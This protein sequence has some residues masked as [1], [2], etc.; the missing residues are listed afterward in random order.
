MTIAETRI[1]EPIWSG[2]DSEWLYR[3][4]CRNYDSNATEDDGSCHGYPDNG[5]YSLVLI[6]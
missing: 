5:N 3:S 1:M 2:L 6:G 4:I